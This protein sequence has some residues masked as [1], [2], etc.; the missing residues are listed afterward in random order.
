MPA[1]RS[2][3]PGHFPRPTWEPGM[4]VDDYAREL[5]DWCDRYEADQEERRLSEDE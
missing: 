2:N 1:T 5:A 4:S 3:L